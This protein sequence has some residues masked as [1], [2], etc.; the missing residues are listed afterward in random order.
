MINFAKSRFSVR[1]QNTSITNTGL[2]AAG[3]R[4]GEGGEGEG[5]SSIEHWLWSVARVTLVLGCE[6]F[7]HVHITVSTPLLRL[8]DPLRV[9][10]AYL[11]ACLGL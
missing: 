11:S 7:L 5:L 8:S 3:W 1:R 9:P 6:G 2:F 10:P 4:G